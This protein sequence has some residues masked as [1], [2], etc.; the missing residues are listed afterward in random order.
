MGLEKVSAGQI[1]RGS[2]TGLGFVNKEKKQKGSG[3]SFSVSQLNLK[4]F[5]LL[6]QKKSYTSLKK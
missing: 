1:T 2:L 4:A 5:F 6:V 3:L